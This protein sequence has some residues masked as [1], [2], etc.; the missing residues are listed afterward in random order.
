LALADYV[1]CASATAVL[2][3]SRIATLDPAFVTRI[4]TT[5]AIPV[6]V[7]PSAVAGQASRT[8]PTQQ[9]AHLDELL[10]DELVFR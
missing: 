6:I 1:E 10:E 9:P 8:V 5:L 7:V 3:P 4:A 2:A